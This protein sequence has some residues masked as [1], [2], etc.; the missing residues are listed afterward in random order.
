[1]K[2]KILLG[3]GLVVLSIGFTGCGGGGEH[4]SQPAPSGPASHPGSHSP[5]YNEGYEYGNQHVENT[6]GFGENT[7]ISQGSVQARR[8]RDDWV[9]GCIDG[10]HD[11][12]NEPSSPE[13]GV[14]S[15]VKAFTDA[16]NKPSVTEIRS[17]WCSGT[18]LD[19]TT[20]GKQID[21]YGHIETSVSDIDNGFGGD[22][23]SATVSVTSSKAGGEKETWSFLKER[24]SWK[25]CK[26]SFLWTRVPPGH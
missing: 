14:R 21:H 2:L 26:T 25:P 24:G 15:A 5:A 22:E 16:W 9:Q 8:D 13:G 7:C 19:A 4:P 12:A 1:M 23:A 17:L 18:A 3:V 20:L 10:M 6:L 11:A